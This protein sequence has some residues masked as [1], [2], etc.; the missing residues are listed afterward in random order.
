MAKI[1][2]VDD[3]DLVREFAQLTLTRAGHTVL[4][5]GSV[6]EA[7]H[8]LDQGDVDLLITDI[9]MPE[10]DGLEL[11]R[12]VR[13]RQPDLPVLAISGGGRAVGLDYLHAARIFGAGD[14][15]NKPFAPRTLTAKVADMLG[16]ANGGQ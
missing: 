15:L 13:R 1:V 5:A 8:I 16:A 7:L 9:F 12:Q 11:V 6:K 10:S 4:P 3:D 2:L 14:T